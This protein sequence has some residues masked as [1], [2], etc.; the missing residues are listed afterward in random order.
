M[1]DKGMN[2]AQ[3]QLW[4]ENKVNP[5]GGC[6]PMLLQLPIFFALNKLYLVFIYT[7]NGIF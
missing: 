5:L 6:L 3:M 7:Y 2:Q 1:N 4:K